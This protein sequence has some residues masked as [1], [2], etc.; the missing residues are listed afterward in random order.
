MFFRTIRF[1][2]PALAVLLCPTVMRAQGGV[3]SSGFTPY[4]VYGFGDLARQGTAYNASIGGAGIGD[5]NI[6]TINVL[7]PAAVTARPEKAFM[8]DFGL[9]NRNVMYNGNAATSIGTQATGDL[10]SANNTFSVH[11]I[12]ASMPIYKNSAFKLGIM[13]YSSV[14]YNFTAHEEDDNMMAEM[15][16]IV[17]KKIGEGTLYQVFLGA[18]ATLWD[19]FSIGVDG[20]YYFGNIER[21]SQVL[22]TTNA[23]YNTIYSG[24]SYVMSGFGAKFG[25]QYSQPLNKGNLTVGATYSLKTNIKGYETRYAYAGTDTVQYNKFNIEG[26][27]IPS[28]FGAGISY[29]QGD[30]WALN[31]DY[32]YQDWNG[33][34][35]EGNPGVDYKP[36]KRQNFHLGFEI[37]PNRYDVRYFFRRWTYRLGA[38]REY[39]YFS[40]NGDQVASTGITLGF[41]APIPIRLY[42]YVNVAV[43]LGQ[44]GTVEN[45]LIRERYC[46]VHLS[47]SL[48]DIWF[49][50]NLYH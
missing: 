46:M 4:S 32:I 31:F 44:R 23:N 40:L 26:Y 24:W 49:Q 21:Y 25:L 12:V 19:K 14:G 45:N 7:N 3:A 39:S 10:K 43:D 22:F 2:I 11:H 15:G 9:E 33:V 36:A 30:K 35:F 27:R 17:Y 41:G 34:E 6:Y 42:N 5:R 16:D 37:T 48:N 28:E 50:K 29:R 47:F 20:N 18:G 38:Y 8:F 1:I 13:P